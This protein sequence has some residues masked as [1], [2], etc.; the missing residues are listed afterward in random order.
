[1]KEPRKIQK[2]VAKAWM[3][4]GFKKKLLSDP[5]ARLKEEGLNVPPGIE[6]RIVE[7]TPN[8]RY[9]V[10]PLKPSAKELSEEHIAHFATGKC[11]FAE[12]CSCPTW[13]QCGPG[14]Y[15]CATGFCTDTNY[16]V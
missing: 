2:I 6:V 14:T 1:M 10:L 8:V 12:T 9:L 11:Q 5:A 16:C 15:A 3:D 7:D 13:K 4:E